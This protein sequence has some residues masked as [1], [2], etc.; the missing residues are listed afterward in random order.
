MFFDVRGVVGWLCAGCAFFFEV[1]RFNTIIFGCRVWYYGCIFVS[2]GSG[3][4]TVSTVISKFCRD[5]VRG[6]Y[7]VCT[8]G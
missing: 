3:R 5:R 7:F 1:G 6:V 2:R 8:I 4:F